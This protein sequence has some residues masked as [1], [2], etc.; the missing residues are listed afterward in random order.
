[1]QIVYAIIFGLVQGV[2]EFLP[3]SSSGHLL[4]AHEW[5][6]LD[7]L[8]SLAF[9]AFLHL[10]TLAALLI[11]F[12]PEIL[13][14]VKAWF[15]SLKKWDLVNNSYQKLAWL[16]ILACLPAGLVGFFAEDFLTKAFRNLGWLA[17]ALLIVGI[18]LLVVEKIYRGQNTMQQLTW[19][20]AVVIG[21]AQILAL[22]PGVSRS[23]IT[24]IAG[25]SQNLNKQEAAKFSFLLS[26]PVVAGAGFKKM[27]ELYQAGSLVGEW[28]VLVVG[29]LAATVS[30]VLVIKYFLN[31]LETKSLR[32]FGWYRILLALVIFGVIFFS[33]NI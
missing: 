3:I 9:D 6:R 32:P 31:Y 12:W 18:I 1:M 24:I 33:G 25:L 30:G 20:Q 22:V 27:L 5:L 13:K 21:L 23:G 29:F 7:F 19:R 17:L 10:G 15:S 8:D 14:L 16:I 11:F 2:T 28:P 26:L 4:L